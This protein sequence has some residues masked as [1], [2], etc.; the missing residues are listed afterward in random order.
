[1]ICL[2]G[3]TAAYFQL[4]GLELPFLDSHRFGEIIGDKC[5]KIEGI[6]IRK[7]RKPKA[8]SI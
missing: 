4:P 5:A 2:F 6:E 3:D 8:I 7:K 1:M